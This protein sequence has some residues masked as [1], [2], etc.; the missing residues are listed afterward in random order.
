TAVEISC[1]S[2]GLFSRLVAYFK[3]LIGTPAQQTEGNTAEAVAVETAPKAETTLPQERQDHRGQRCQ[4]NG[5]C[6]RNSELTRED[7]ENR[8]PLKRREGRDDARRKRPQAVTETES[9]GDII[10]ETQKE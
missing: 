5:Y 10:G 4:Q 2:R 6:E 3:S 8:Q 1:A 7:Q 9:T